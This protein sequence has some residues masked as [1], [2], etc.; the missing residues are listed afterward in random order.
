MDKVID[1]IAQ[2]GQGTVAKNLSWTYYKSQ[3]GAWI[4]RKEGTGADY[5]AR[6]GREEELGCADRNR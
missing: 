2:A 5:K 6:G 1:Y 3:A 4:S